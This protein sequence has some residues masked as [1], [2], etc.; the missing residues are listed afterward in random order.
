LQRHPF[1]SKIKN[2]VLEAIIDYEREFDDIINIPGHASVYDQK[3]LIEQCQRMTLLG[4][5]MLEGH[6]K[7]FYKSLMLE[8]KISLCLYYFNQQIQLN[9]YT[10]VT[11][12]R[13]RMVMTGPPGMIARCVDPAYATHIQ[14]A[15]NKFDIWEEER[16]IKAP[17]I[18]KS[19]IID[20]PCSISFLGGED[21]E[22]KPIDIDQIDDVVHIYENTFDDPNIPLKKSEL[23]VF[24]HKDDED[25]NGEVM[26]IDEDRLI[27]KKPF[28]IKGNNDIYRYIFQFIPRMHCIPYMLVCKTWYNVVL[29]Y[30]LPYRTPSRFVHISEKHHENVVTLSQVHVS[31][32]DISKKLS[33]AY[34]CNQQFVDFLMKGLL[35]S[36]PS[37][38][39]VLWPILPKKRFC[40]KKTILFFNILCITIYVPAGT[41]NSVLL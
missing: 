10:D 34:R 32:A 35:L 14:S 24:V 25:D 11:Y 9:E 40:Y 36:L 13:I 29:L 23:K 28:K 12:H 4:D 26:E 22:V 21:I 17:I 8:E 6:Y 37:M 7:E 2:E 5:F 18:V 16:I 1:Y 30:R 19:V 33:M 3:S 38:S 15:L 31:L 41:S 39:Y 27:N 20:K